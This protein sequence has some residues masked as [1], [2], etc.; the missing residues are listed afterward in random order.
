M[1]QEVLAA[2]LITQ[3]KWIFD[4]APGVHLQLRPIEVLI[5]GGKS[6]FIEMVPDSISID[7]LK[8]L[9]PEQSLNEIFQTAF[10]DRL[11][12]AKKNFTESIAAY[13]LVC[14]FLQVRDRH[15]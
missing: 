2:Q 10:A 1:R 7:R 8:R 11:Y 12:S 3:F 9:Y 14:Y 5:T 4:Q 6:G 13:S 15:N